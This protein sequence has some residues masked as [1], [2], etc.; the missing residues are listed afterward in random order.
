MPSDV[1]RRFDGVGRLAQIGPGQTGAA[2]FALLDNAGEVRYYVTPSPGVN[3]RPY[4]GRE[5]GVN[6]T[7]GFMPD[8]RTQHVTAKRITVVDD[9]IVR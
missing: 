2:G 8:A 6:G 5:V 9:R 1:A 7:L 3:L 4:L